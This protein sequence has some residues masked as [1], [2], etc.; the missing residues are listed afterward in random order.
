MH[1]NGLNCDLILNFYQNILTMTQRSLQ[2]RCGGI[3]LL[4]KT[5]KIR[6]LLC[7]GWYDRVHGDSNTLKR[8]MM[9]PIKQLT[10]ETIL[11]VCIETYG[12]LSRNVKHIWIYPCWK[13]WDLQ[14][15]IMF[16]CC[17]LLCE[18]LHDSLLMYQ[19]A[20][21]W[22]PGLPVLHMTR[23][24]Q[25]LQS[26]LLRSLRVARSVWIIWPWFTLTDTDDGI[27]TEKN[28]LWA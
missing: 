11:K 16:S 28:R 24:R 1:V 2:K 19:R 26:T 9:L 21:P 17:V 27:C 23:A 12:R 25:R 6:T 10:V 20:A 22:L 13:V 7:V 18:S 8:L 5:M 4:R 15:E 3:S 14:S